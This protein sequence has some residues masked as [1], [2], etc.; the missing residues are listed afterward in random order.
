MV[1]IPPFFWRK[2]HTSPGEQAILNDLFTRILMPGVFGV[3][4]TFSDD[5]L[6]EERFF[7]ASK[8]QFP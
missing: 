8:R 4:T 6:D 2:S 1:Q 7:Q 5:A 3:F